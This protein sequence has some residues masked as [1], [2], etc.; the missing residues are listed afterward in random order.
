MKL[1]R[2]ENVLTVLDHGGRVEERDGL[3]ALIGPDGKE[4]AAWQNAIK[5]AQKVAAAR[6]APPRDQQEAIGLI[7]QAL[8]DAE[9]GARIDCLDSLRMAVSAVE[10]SL[11]W[12]DSRRLLLHALPIADEA[13]RSDIE[14]ACRV[15]AAS[16]GLQWY[17]VGTVADPDDRA[18]VMRACRYLLLRGD[19]AHGYT[20]HYHPDRGD[21]IRFET[22]P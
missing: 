4:V 22:T 20:V 12:P 8:K 1:T 11:Q 6:K 10:E 17:E 14:C 13:A 7:R 9:R 21:L 5:S 2:T 3:L 15:A 18:A 19:H 16:D